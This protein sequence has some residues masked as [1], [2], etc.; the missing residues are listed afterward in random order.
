MY[1]LQIYSQEDFQG[2]V[3]LISKVLMN[4]IFVKMWIFFLSLY[5][6]CYNIASVLHFSFLACSIL[7]P[8]LGIEPTSPALEGEFLTVEPPEKS[9]D[10]F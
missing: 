10:E 4:F 1:H 5:W 3:Y 2:K 6:I 9:P 7:A 8:Q